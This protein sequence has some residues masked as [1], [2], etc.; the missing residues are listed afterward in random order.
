MRWT[1]MA[2]LLELRDGALARSL[3][4]APAAQLRAVA[5]AVVRDVVERDL[6]DQL[7]PQRD[8]LELALAVPPARVAHAALARLI[9]RERPR[10]LPL[11]LGLEAGGVA[12]DAELA[13][14]VV[15]AEDQRADRPLLLAGAPADDDR[16]DRADALDLHHP[17]ALAGA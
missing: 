14:V 4:V 17:D 7:R 9:R 11:L 15:E 2:S 1:G 3:V 6:D 8:P 13:G 16:V 10:Q 12:D 5:D